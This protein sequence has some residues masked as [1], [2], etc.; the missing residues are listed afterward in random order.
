M[1]EKIDLSLTIGAFKTDSI[2]FPSK[3]F[4]IYYLPYAV[5]IVLLAVGCELIY[6]KIM[7]EFHRLIQIEDKIL[8]KLYP[9]RWILFF[10]IMLEDI[11]LKVVGE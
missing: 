7:A 10:I 8:S 4:I 9:A 5:I 2:K 6:E 3:Y 11:L 1:P